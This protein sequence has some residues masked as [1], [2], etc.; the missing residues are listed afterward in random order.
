MP[1][2]SPPLG[3]RKHVKTFQIISIAMFRKT[4][5]RKEKHPGRIDIS[6]SEEYK[7]DHANSELNIIECLL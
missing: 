7:S 2:M 4:I 5:F 6:R 3:D 1:L